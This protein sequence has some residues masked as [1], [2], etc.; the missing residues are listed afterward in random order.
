[1]KRILIGCVL[2]GGV[3]Y[4]ACASKP[5]VIKPAPN[6]GEEM[7]WTDHKDG[8]PAWTYKEPEGDDKNLLFV[9]VSGKYATEKEVRDDALRS[10]IN[11][12]V[13]Y[14]GT[15]VNDNFQRLTASYGLSTDIINSTV[16]TRQFEEQLNSALASHV[17]AREYYTEKWKTKINET[18]YVAYVLSFV[19][20]DSVNNA[21]QQTMDGQ[22]EELKKKRDAAND[23]KAKEQY[24]NAMKAFEE[25]KKQGFNPSK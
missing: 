20:R 11:N 13:R 7:I 22:I 24:N 25:A 15:S 21:Y 17:K 23:E 4:A 2:A 10:S 5:E 6:I 12:V 9:G 1:M 14:I 18:Y 16:A 3:F 19:P 8:R